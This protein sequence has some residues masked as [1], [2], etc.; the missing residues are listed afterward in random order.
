[1][2][3]AREL[4]D[5]LEERFILGEISEADYH[6][7]RAG[8]LEK[9][10]IDADTAAAVARSSQSAGKEPHDG[11][12]G[13][14]AG[15]VWTI[16]LWGGLVLPMVWIP[17]GRFIMGGYHRGGMNPEHEVHISHGFWI[18]KYPVTEKQYAHMIGESMATPRGDECPVAY[19][20]RLDALEFIRLVNKRLRLSPW[21]PFRLPTES[22]WEYACRAGS[23]CA[24]YFGDDVSQLKDHAWFFENT[25]SDAELKAAARGKGR[26]VI[27][28]RKDP[29]FI[30]RRRPV[31]C[32]QGNAW[33]LHDMLGNVWEWCEDRYIPERSPDSP[34]GK[35][36]EPSV[37][38]ILRG[39]SWRDS[40]DQC[41]ASY[42]NA[43]EQDF[44]W[45][46]VGF[47]L[48]ADGWARDTWLAGRALVGLDPPR[49]R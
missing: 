22:E 35:H 36:D 38:H 49:N 27:R 19:V 43:H 23:K 6:E 39:G 47:R 7:L 3:S 34:Y 16:D 24:Y 11:G 40:A 44:R 26:C 2:K 48:A 1:M 30:G 41:R 4:L 8:L 13:V 42:W 28:G 15:S 25:A 33:G 29:P 46:D 5:V 18:G 12:S 17:E 32:K 9:I 21:R 45:W 31:G 10:A 14:V 20:S 37:D